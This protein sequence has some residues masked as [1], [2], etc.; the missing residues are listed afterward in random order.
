M[1]AKLEI[2]LNESLCLPLPGGSAR[3]Q[4]GNAAP[5]A[6]ETTQQR[7]TASRRGTSPGSQKCLYF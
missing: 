7:H 5:G 2:F 1:I 6:H 4:P 3:E